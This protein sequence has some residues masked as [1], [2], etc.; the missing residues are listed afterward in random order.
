MSVIIDMILFS[1]RKARMFVQEMPYSSFWRHWVVENIEQA[2]MTLEGW[3]FPPLEAPFL[4]TRKL[5]LRPPPWRKVVL[6]GSS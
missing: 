1:M 4:M 5:Q 2:H 6:S 3:C